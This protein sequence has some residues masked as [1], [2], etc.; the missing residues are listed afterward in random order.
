MRGPAGAA[1]DSAREEAQ[2]VCGGQERGPL[3]ENGPSPEH[4]G[5]GVRLEPSGCRGVGWDRSPLQS[6]IFL[7]QPTSNRRS[8]G[9]IV[10][11][12]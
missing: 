12:R 3:G 1:R 5:I 11:L 10:R 4:V 8:K 6:R 9:K 2:Q 7:K